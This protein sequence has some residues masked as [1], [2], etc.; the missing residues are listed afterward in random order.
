MA[1][2][3][4]YFSHDY[5]AR[6]DDKILELR[7]HY[8]AEGYGI[9][10]MI[11]ETMAENDNGGIKAS[12]IGGLSVA[13]GVAKERL[14][15]IINSCKDIGLF[16]EEN[17]F[18]YSKRLLTHKEIRTYYSQKGKEG[19]EKRW[20]NKDGNGGAIAPLMQR[21][22][23]ERKEKEIINKGLEKISTEIQGLGLMEIFILNNCEQWQLNS[24]S[25]FITKSTI[26][27]QAMAMNKPEMKNVKNFEL[28]LQAFINRIQEGG[29]YQETAALKRYFKNWINDKNGSLDDFIKQLKSTGKNIS[30]N[31][32]V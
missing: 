17:G 13:Y 29:E 4:F 5:N 30:V 12:L 2:D 10:W 25:D 8:G 26:E 18:F 11:V 19:A 32:Y 27:F 1:K 28:L 21:K 31:S 22:G 15:E 6:N 24:V 23:K 9:F 14:I 3:S 20:K 16:Y 7:L